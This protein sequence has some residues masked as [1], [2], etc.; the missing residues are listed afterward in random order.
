MASPADDSQSTS[1]SLIARLQKHDEQAWHRFADVYGPL[2]YY[3]CR[4][5]GLSAEDATDV[6]QE[7]FRSVA[8][9][10]GSFRKERPGDTFRGWLHTIT[11][12][13]IRDH[14]R[15]GARRAEATGGTDA[16]Q[17]LLQVPG[18]VAPDFDSGEAAALRSLLDRALDLV[19][20]DFSEQ[21]WQAFSLAV[22]Q[23]RDTAEVAAELG[24]SPNAVRKAK[25]R[26]LQRL[27]EELG[28]WE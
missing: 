22:F 11:Q 27:R 20:G 24:I 12:N 7:A 25:A 5:A 23:G 18:D 13:K 26:V 4:R 1:V 14:F 3:W 16:Q 17:F 19:R 9:G 10:I 2:V 21:T 15:A 6:A 8:A 28:E